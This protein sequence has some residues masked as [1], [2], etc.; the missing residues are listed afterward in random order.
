MLHPC[1]VLADLLTIAEH[2]G[3]LAPEGPALAGRALAYIGDG[4]NNMAHSYLLGGA[5]AGLDVRI[6]APAE[7]APDREIVARAEQIAEATGGS[8]LV[9]TDP[10]LAVAGVHAVATDTWVSMGQETQAG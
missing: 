2:R 4:A 7:Y 8:V 9:T 10:E 5:T 3:G 1:Q 6:A